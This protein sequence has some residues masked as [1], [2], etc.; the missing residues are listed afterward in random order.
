MKKIV[1][2]LGAASMTLLAACGSGGQSDARGTSAAPAA[3]G[4]LIDEYEAAVGNTHP[5]IAIKPISKPAPSGKTLEVI[6]CAVPICA[7][8]TEGAT[9]AAQAL[10]WKTKTVVASFT[11]E[12]FKE[13]WD[14]VLQDKPDAVVMAGVVP[15]DTVIDQVTQANEQGIVVVGYG[16]DVQAGGDSPF[17]FGTTSAKALSVDGREQGLAVIND[18]KG[19][20]DVLIVNDPAQVPTK[21]QVAASTEVLKSVGSRVALLKVSSSEIGKGVPAQIVTNLQANPGVKYVLLP[22]DDFLSGVPQA[23]K[24]AGLDHVKVVGE[25]ASEESKAALENGQLLASTA[26]PVLINGWYLVDA[27]VRKMVGDPIADANPMWESVIVTRDNV[28]D[29]GNLSEWPHIQAEFT[30][31]W[32]IG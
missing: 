14:T 12:G 19:A 25:A 10:G 26:H 31:A 30:S 6:T 1:I 15:T 22:N 16:L 9:K 23:L 27:I 8:Y 24:S 32:N 18:A 3:V 28:D 2:A 4:K 11:P 7:L 13:T 5:D 29:L 20:T 21:A 17:T